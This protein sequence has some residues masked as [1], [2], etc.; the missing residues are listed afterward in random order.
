VLLFIGIIGSSAFQTV[1]SEPSAIVVPDDFPT[2]QE[3]IN[4]A[5]SGDSIFVRNGTYH[6]HLIVNKTVSI[7]GED[8]TATMLDGNHT[9][10]VVKV[11][12]SNATISGFTI[13][14]GEIG[15]DLNSNNNTITSNTISSNGAQ[16]TDLKTNLEI[17]PEPPSVPIWRFLYEL[18]DSNYTEFLD[19]TTDT[20]I[21]NVEVIG[22][23]DVAELCLGLFYDENMDGVPQLNEYA[24]FGSRDQVTGVILPNPAKGRYIIKVQGW[25]VLGNPG[26]FDREIT[27][28]NGYGIGAHQTYNNTISQN[29]ILDNGAGLYLQSCSNVA[30]H[31]N[32]LTRNLGAIVVGDTV[33]SA[34]YDNK[35]FDNN[36]TICLRTSR[37]ISVTNNILSS[38]VFGIHIWNSSNINI[39]ENELHSHAGW[40]IG[41]IS[42]VDSNVANNNI[43][44][45]TVLDGIRLMFSSRNNLTEN[46]ISYCEHSGIL[47]WY[48]CWD[49]E[50]TDNDIRSSGSQGWGHGHGIEVLLSHDNIFADNSIRYARNQG[51][52][53][54]E[55]SDNN[56]TENLFSS[57]R[58]GIEIK[59]SAGNRVYHN[60]IIN[61]SEL[62]G[63]DDTG[64][65]FWDDGYPSGGNYWSDYAGADSC[66][67]FYQNETGNDGM[68]DTPYSFEGN[69][70][71]YPLIFPWGGFTGDINGDRVVDIFDVTTVA[72]AFNSEPGDPNWNEIADINNDNL[73]DIFDIVIVAVHFGETG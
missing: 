22:H 32:N 21:L 11:T 18:M 23:S 66:Y 3:A 28:F 16:E 53:L 62:Q 63:R 30:V 6:E 47:L 12:A 19:L 54:I 26:H 35:A 38:N 14:N 10:T 61:N 48:D 41:L 72:L 29:L 31:T 56:I 20:P 67:G 44:T 17:Y 64:E 42:S 58:K 15:L 69:T 68:G 49:N 27:K 39:T 52:V 7:V 25:N 43:S 50:I 13:Q 60:S 46:N 33:N 36:Q 70:D 8:R 57:N 73:V 9:G 24:G 1:R 37:N 4:N 59:S 40:S 2:I 51:I 5:N 45:V 71:H 34:F 65:N 55:T